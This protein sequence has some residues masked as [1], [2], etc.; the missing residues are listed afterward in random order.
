MLADEALAY[1][2]VCRSEECDKYGYWVD[3]GQCSATN[4]TIPGQVTKCPRCSSTF[5]AKRDGHRNGLDLMLVFNEI[6]EIHFI[7]YHQTRKKLKRENSI[8]F[9]RLQIV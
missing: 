1:R 7:V 3:N 6:G 8:G 4:R 2:W 5:N 9:R